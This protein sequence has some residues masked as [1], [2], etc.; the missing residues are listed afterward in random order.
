MLVLLVAHGVDAPLEQLATFGREQFA[1]AR[2]VLEGDRVPTHGFEHA[3][4]PVRS[5]ARHDPVERLAVQVDDP[6]DLAQLRHPGVH[7][8]FPHGALVELAVADERDVA[9]P[10]GRAEVGGHITLR[11]CA[12]Y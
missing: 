2:P 9:T 4:D 10:L 5:N 1:E 11:N 8:R 6:K 12:P 7:E 3:P